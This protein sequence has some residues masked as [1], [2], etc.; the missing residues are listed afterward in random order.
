MNKNTSSKNQVLTNQAIPALTIGI[1]LGDEKHAI[2]V[3][4]FTDEVFVR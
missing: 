4:D 3:L 1:D 2:C